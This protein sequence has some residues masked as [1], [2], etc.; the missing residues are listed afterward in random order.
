MKHFALS[1]SLAI[2]RYTSSPCPRCNICCFCNL[3]A[4]F[5]VYFVSY[6]H[7]SD[8]LIILHID[9]RFMYI[10]YCFLFVFFSLYHS[11]MNK[12][13][14]WRASL[15]GLA[16]RRRRRPS[17]VR[18]ATFPDRAS[19]ITASTRRT[20]GRPRQV[21]DR[22]TANNQRERERERDRGWVGGGGGGQLEITGDVD[23]LSD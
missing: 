7:T 12:V 16:P 6:T 8:R 1:T 17:C 15:G 10:L 18:H 5:T 4:L 20:D 14:Q 22:P 19:L 11:L 23:S 3:N 9:R 2:T 13:A 21:D